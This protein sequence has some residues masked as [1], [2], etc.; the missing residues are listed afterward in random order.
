[1]A[2][3]LEGQSAQDDF[4]PLMDAAAIDDRVEMI[5]ADE[6]QEVLDAMRQEIESGAAAGEILA[7]VLKI[8]GGALALL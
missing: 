3:L 2:D 4:Q 7:K 1:M 6:A 5:G 8:G